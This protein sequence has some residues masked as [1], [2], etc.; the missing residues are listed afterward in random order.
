MTDVLFEAKFASY[1]VNDVVRF[2]GA[3]PNGVVTS[4]CDWTRYPTGCV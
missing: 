4:P 2:T 1:A 3:T